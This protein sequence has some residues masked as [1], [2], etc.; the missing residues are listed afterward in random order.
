MTAASY[1]LRVG[2]FPAMIVKDGTPSTL[3]LPEVMGEPP[4]EIAGDSIG[5]LGGLLVVDTPHGRI[6]VDAGNGPHR[7]PRAYAAEATLAAEGIDPSSVD[8]VLITHGDFDHIGGLIAADRRPVYRNARYVLHRDLWDFWHDAE[9]RSEYPA[10]AVALWDRILPPLVSAI[11]ANATIVEAEREI[12]AGIRAIPALGHRVGHTIYR[13]E[14]EGESLFHIGDAA[15]HPIFLEH[16]DAVNVRHDTEPET[17]RDARRRIAQRASAEDALV[18]GTHFLLPG[19]GQLT[20]IAEDRYTWSS[21]GGNRECN[22][23]TEHD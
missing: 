18:I 15:V 9:S 17:A 3:A 20:M 10:E 6:L 7:G 21:I 16:T 2:D 14:S 5:M 13:I 23:R 11:A 8:T 1:R 19:I 22:E 4:A 12:G